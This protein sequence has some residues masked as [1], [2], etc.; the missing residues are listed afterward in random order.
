MLLEKPKVEK[1]SFR[2][3]FRPE[4]CYAAQGGAA[5]SVSEISCGLARP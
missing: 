2:P 4:C 3:R 1:I 5:L